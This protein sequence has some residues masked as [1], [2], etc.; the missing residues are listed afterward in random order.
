M[1]SDWPQAPYQLLFG[2]QHCVVGNGESLGVRVPCDDPPFDSSQ[3]AKYVCAP[4]DIGDECLCSCAQ[5]EGRKQR[6]MCSSITTGKPAV[7]IKCAQ[8]QAATPSPRM[9]IFEN[10]LLLPGSRFGGD[11]M[12][13]VPIVFTAGILD[14]FRQRGIQLQ[15]SEDAR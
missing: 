13:N 2:H 6:S 7:A 4:E 14:Q 11:K 9:I 5:Q 3:A 10:L 12:L 8:Q 1:K 15:R